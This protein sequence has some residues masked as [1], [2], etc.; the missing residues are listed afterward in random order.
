MGCIF[1][2]NKSQINTNLGFDWL[3]KVKMTM[4]KLNMRPTSN[5]KNKLW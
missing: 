5:I 4:Q 3:K 2:Y 1:A